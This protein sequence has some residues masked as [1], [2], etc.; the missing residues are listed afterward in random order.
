MVGIDIIEVERIDASDKFLEKIA[1]QEEIDFINKAKCDKL[2]KQKIAA[3]FCVKESVMKALEM[4]AKSGVVFKDI[5]L[6]HEQSGKPFVVL[7]GKALDKYN[8][9]FAGKKIEVS[10]SHTEKYAT[11]IAILM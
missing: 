1:F 6:C 9:C 2:R 4:G 7:H 3:L 11:A 10:L 5:Q 8:Q